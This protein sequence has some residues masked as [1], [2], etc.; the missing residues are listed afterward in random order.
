MVVGIAQLAEAVG[1]GAAGVQ[2]WDL[3]AAAQHPQGAGILQVQLVE[4]GGTQF[5][6]IGAGAQV[7]HR[8]HLR[9]VA[10]QP[11]NEI[12]AVH[13]APQLLV[14]YVPLLIGPGKIIHGQHVGVA[15]FV[16]FLNHAGANKARRAG[17]YDHGNGLR[18]WRVLKGNLQKAKWQAY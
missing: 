13:L 4:D 6:R 8:V 5:R 18:R 14:V 11:A 9:M 15:C 1:G 7:D 16:E 2:K 3:E 12:I 10:L 17:N